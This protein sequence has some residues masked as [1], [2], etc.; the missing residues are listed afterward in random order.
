MVSIKLTDLATYVGFLK[1]NPQELE[2]LFKEFLIGVTSFFREPMEWELLKDKVI[3]A[4]LVG[5]SPT[6]T[7]RVWISGCSTGEEAYSLAIVFK[8]VLDQL[9]PSQ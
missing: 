2:L 9:K 3:P 4:L 1:E 8:D 6:D 5:R 7:L